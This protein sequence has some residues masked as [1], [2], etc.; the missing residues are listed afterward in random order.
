VRLGMSVLERRLQALEASSGG[1]RG[2]ER[3]RG[4]LVTVSHAITGEFLSA[5]WNGETVSEEEVTG[6]RSETKCPRCGRKIDQ[7]EVPVIK[8][9]GLR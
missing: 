5:T 4:L 2:C 8:V 1:D 3:C 6:R 7:D 9:R